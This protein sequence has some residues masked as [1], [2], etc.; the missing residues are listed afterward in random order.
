MLVMEHMRTRINQTTAHGQFWMLLLSQGHVRPIQRM[1]AFSGVHDIDNISGKS[2]EECRFWAVETPQA[3]ATGRLIRE[4]LRST[5]PYEVPEEMML[6]S[7]RISR[8]DLFLGL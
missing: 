3:H 4:S 5:E 7:C 2:V 8:S 1:I 6:R